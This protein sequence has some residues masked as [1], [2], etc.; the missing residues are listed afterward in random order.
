MQVDEAGHEQ[1]AG[2]VD[3]AH[4]LRRRDPS[5]DGGDLALPNQDVQLDVQAGQRVDDARAADEQV[6]L[7]GGRTP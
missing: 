2:G 6:G 7:G 3:A 1:L 4:A 5:T